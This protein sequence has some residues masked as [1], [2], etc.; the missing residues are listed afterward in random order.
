MKILIVQPTGDKLGHFGIYT[1]NLAQALAIAGHDVTV[2]TNR[3]DA[4]AF[5]LEPRRFFIV[6][7]PNCAF[8]QNNGNVASPSYL[9]A[10][11]RNSYKVL[12]HALAIADDFDLMYVMDCEFLMATIALKRHRP[13]IPVV[14][15]ISAAN[16]S[17]A[18]YAGSTPFKAYKVFQ[19]EIFKTTLGHEIQ[20]IHTLGHYQSAELMDQLNPPA[21]FPIGAIH[22]APTRTARVPQAAARKALAIDYDGPLLLFFGMLR[23]DKGI[24]DLLRAVWAAGSDYRLL[25]AGHP[26]DYTPAQ[27][28]ELIIRYGVGAKVFQHLFYVP[29]D[30]VTAYFSA[31]D[32]LVLPYRSSYTGGSGPLLKQA[33]SYGLP[34]IVTDVAEMG[35]L[36]RHHGF[37]TVTHPDNPAALSMAIDGVMGDG[38][39]RAALGEQARKLADIY[40][41]PNAAKGLTALFEAAIAYKGA[42]RG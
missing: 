17:F 39:Y 33:G 26:M 1:T 34:V 36:V 20:G 15:Y 27:V 16:F 18:A 32:A 25:L 9:R 14:M 22:D 31:A 42:R 11:F 3:L 37:G 5:L 41:W 24:E 28:D 8:D 13:K 40:S 19:R 10:Y 12:T 4:T 7:T 35:S 30:Q 38:G 2:C 23:R 29:E 21:G 6:P